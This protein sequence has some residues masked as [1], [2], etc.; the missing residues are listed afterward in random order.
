MDYCIE[1][2]ELAVSLS[3]MGGEITSARAKDGTEYIWQGNP[4]YWKKRAPHLFPYVGRLTKGTYS[5][6]GRLWEMDTHGFFRWREMACTQHSRASVTFTMQSDEDTLAQYPRHWQVTL[7]YQLSGPTL[8]IAF[9]VA[10]TGSKEMPFAYGGHP[11]FCV[12]LA[13]AP[14]FEDYCIEF[15]KTA[16]PVAVEMSE[17]CFV[18]S[19]RTPLALQPQNRLWLR[20]NLFDNDAIVLHNAGSVAALK[21]SAPGHSVAVHFTGMPYLAL[22]Q[23]PHTDAP[24]VCIE[25]WTSLPSRQ[26]VVEALEEKDDMLRLAPGKSTEIEW[27]ITFQ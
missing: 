22:W 25:P 19:G 6:D 24:F 7:C 10:N 18:Q 13:P 11:G 16:A 4:Q 26:D 2:D 9:C 1:N 3:S 15:E 17:S 21:S 12:P 14:G 20:H 5:L 27:A 23:P 8:H